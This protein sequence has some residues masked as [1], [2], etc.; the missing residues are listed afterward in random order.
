MADRKSRKR[1]RRRVAGALGLLIVTTLT[2]AEAPRVARRIARAEVF[3]VGQL[4]LEGARYLKLEDAAR[5]ANVPAEAS[6]WD[7]PTEWEARLA[8]HPLVK[9]A[10]VK[11][12]IP[13]TL[14]LVVEER[15]PVALIPTPTL[16]AVDVEGKILPLDPSAHRLDLPLLRVSGRGKAAEKARAA[17]AAEAERLARVDPE[18]AGRI[19]ELARDERGDLIASWGS[20][21]V[22]IRFTSSVTSRKLREGLRVLADVRSDSGELPATV[23]LRFEEQVVVRRTQ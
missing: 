23:D 4:E 17:L 22:T 3:R 19:S 16:E 11:R 14:V 20:P 5:S 10:R 18:F 1:R 15:Q 8:E 9:L 13:S 6:V 2:V 12:K 21:Q 7:D